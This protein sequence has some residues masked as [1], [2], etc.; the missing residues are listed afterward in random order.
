M[1]EG[2]ALLS[3]AWASISFHTCS[4]HFGMRVGSRS[5]HLS[6]GDGVSPVWGVLR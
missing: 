1:W 4:R 6:G 5:P 3:R 2:V